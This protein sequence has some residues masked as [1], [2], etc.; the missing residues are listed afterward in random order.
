MPDEKEEK[1]ESRMKRVLVDEEAAA[2]MY[3]YIELN[4]GRSYLNPGGAGP[5]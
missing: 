5:G 2:K 3:S 4:Y 1:R